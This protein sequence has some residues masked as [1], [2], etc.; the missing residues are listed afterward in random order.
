MTKRRDFLE[1]MGAM[2]ALAPAAEAEALPPALEE[3]P[4]HHIRFAG[5]RHQPR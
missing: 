3:K 1:S 5:L 2:L 4:K